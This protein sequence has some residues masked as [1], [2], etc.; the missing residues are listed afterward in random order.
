MATRVHYRQSEGNS[1]SSPQLQ[2]QHT[3]IRQAHSTS[4]HFHKLPIHITLNHLD[5]PSNNQTQTANKMFA[6]KTITALVASAAL[7][8][9]ATA[10]QATVYNNGDCSHS[11]ANYFAYSGSGSSPCITVGLADG[12]TCSYHANGGTSQ[13]DCGA[14]TYTTW[15]N[16]FYG[17]KHV[18]IFVPSGTELTY[19]YTIGT[20]T[21]DI[22]N[23]SNCRTVQGDS[24]GTCMQLN[25]AGLQNF[26][27][28]QISA[29]D[30]AAKGKVKS[31]KA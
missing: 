30:R 23:G 5:I 12:A 13:S 7:I 16:E 11:D 19:C 6:L 3:P 31:F 28:V 2:P 24:D 18:S 8:A 10:W 21:C 15:L 25:E 27:T 29:V 26:N 20:N 1:A 9:P 17:P 14:S 4:N 22:N